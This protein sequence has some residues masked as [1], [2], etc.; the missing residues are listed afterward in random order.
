MTF[1][2]FLAWAAVKLDYRASAAGD[3][4]GAAVTPHRGPLSCTFNITTTEGRLTYS[5]LP[6]SL[7]PTGFTTDVISAIRNLTLDTAYCHTTDIYF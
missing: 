4:A 3:F 5:V 2:A 7:L 1:T 6:N